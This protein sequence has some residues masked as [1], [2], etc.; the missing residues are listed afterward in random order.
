[1]V[2]SKIVRF[3]VPGAPS[4]SGPYVH[5]LQAAG[6]IFCAGQGSKDPDTGVEAGLER[7]GGEVVSYDIHAQARGCFRNLA[8]VLAAAGSDLSRVVEVNVFLKDM[9]D[10]TAMNEVFG[11][12]FGAA[13]PVRTTIGVADLPGNN[14]IE[15]RAL[16]LAKD[17]NGGTES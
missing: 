4:P 1:M 14:F 17:A 5:A 11:E 10:F 2:M 8:A 9:G 3:E 6:F 7:S 12:V 13:Q 16:A 15:L